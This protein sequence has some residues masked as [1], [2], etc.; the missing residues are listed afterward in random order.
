MAAIW[1]RVIMFLFELY[2]NKKKSNICNNKLRVPE[3]IP[4]GRESTKQEKTF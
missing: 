1:Q 4:A 2:K 3:S